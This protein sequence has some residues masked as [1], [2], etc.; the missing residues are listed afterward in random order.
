[1]SRVPTINRPVQSPA[2]D[3]IPI[4]ATVD[5][6]RR[7]SGIGRSKLYELIAANALKSV[8][9]GRRRLILVESIRGLGSSN[10]AA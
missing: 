2:H 4:W 7:L 6:A 5:D 3:Q 1:M 9:V 8:K 10:A